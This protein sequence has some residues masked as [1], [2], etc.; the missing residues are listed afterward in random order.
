M[1][2]HVNF[3]LPGRKSKVKGGESGHASQLL[4]GAAF[5]PA[6]TLLQTSALQPLR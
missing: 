3:P 2:D 5:M 1:T 4:V 6:I